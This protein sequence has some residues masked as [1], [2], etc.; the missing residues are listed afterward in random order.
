MEPHDLD[1]IALAGGLAATGGAVLYLT[2]AGTGWLLPAALTAAG[3]V[4]AASGLRG[5]RGSPGD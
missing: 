5:R 2:G 4:V 1:P 3:V